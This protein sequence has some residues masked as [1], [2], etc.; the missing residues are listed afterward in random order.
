MAPELPK[1]LEWIEHDNATKDAG[2]TCRKYGP[3]KKPVCR[4]ANTRL[5]IHN[6]TR[7]PGF[8]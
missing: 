4:L 1:R 6:A 5:R 3:G 7:F 8:M 2:L